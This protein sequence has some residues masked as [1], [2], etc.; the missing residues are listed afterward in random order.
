MTVMGALLPN[1]EWQL[2]GVHRGK[3]DDDGGDCLDSHRPKA[4]VG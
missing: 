1:P 4:A 2:S 3:A